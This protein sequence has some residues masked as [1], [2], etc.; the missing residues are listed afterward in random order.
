MSRSRTDVESSPALPPGRHVRVPKRGTFFVR[1]AP[2][3]P[4]APT[5]VLLHGWLATGGLNWFRVFEPL[6]RYFRVIAP[7]LR[8]HGRGLKTWR[9]FR[10][11][12]CAD[13]VGAI[14]RRMSRGPAIVAG[15][16]MGGPVAQLLWRRHS[17]LVSGL[18]LCAT[19]DKLLPGITE[20]LALGSMAMAVAGTTRIGQIP[21]ALPRWLA[22][23]MA[24]AG[25]DE[26]PSEAG[27][28][29]QWAADEVRGHDLRMVMEAGYAIA[30]YDATSWTE[31]IGVPTSVVM[32]MDD[33]A[34]LERSQRGMAERIPTARVFPV[35]DGH[36]V[37]SRESFQQP[38][39]DACLDV[40]ERILRSR[41]QT[42]SAAPPSIRKSAPLM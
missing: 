42:Q 3:P 37:C 12:D 38:L 25:A 1:E 16:S 14:I 24:S 13:D 18:V 17:P 22:R 15:Y 9:R 7:D 35:P 19:S 5:L 26:S 11:E 6:S 28:P 41:G 30:Q 40:H 8:G 32:T 4:G 39:L 31:S 2:G 21:A 27:T 36:V 33:R 34:V 29:S 20:R 23:R 10:L